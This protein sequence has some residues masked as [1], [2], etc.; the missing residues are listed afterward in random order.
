M[1][2]A[3]CTV[4]GP[5][6]APLYQR[7]DR[8]SLS[9]SCRNTLIWWTWYPPPVSSRSLSALSLGT[10]I[11]L[12]VYEEKIFPT[13]LVPIHSRLLNPGFFGFVAFTSTKSLLA[14]SVSIMR[15]YSAIAFST[16]FCFVHFQSNVAADP[17]LGDIEPLYVFTPGPAPG[18]CDN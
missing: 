12:I 5:R 2:D 15:Y 4:K 8:L 7:Q 3:S 16:L 11:C 17:K 14:T 18:N 1:Y 6:T 13:S 9:L 10:C